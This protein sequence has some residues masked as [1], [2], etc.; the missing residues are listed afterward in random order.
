VRQKAIREGGALIDRAGMTAKANNDTFKRKVGT[1]VVAIRRGGA[2]HAF[3]SIN[4]FLSISQMVIPGASYWNVG[5]GRKIGDV[6]GDEEG[7]VT[8]KILGQNMACGCYKNCMDDQ[9]VGAGRLA[10]AF[11]GSSYHVKY[12]SVHAIPDATSSFFLSSVRS[13]SV[14]PTPTVST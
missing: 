9:V 5:I 14:V 12:R 13:K 6:E 7:I 2:I 10:A 4:H 1:A 3:D 11:L 8:M